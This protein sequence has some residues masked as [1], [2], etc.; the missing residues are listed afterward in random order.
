M[1]NKST[2]Y[3]IC[4][5]HNEIERLRRLLKCFGNQTFKNYKLVIVDDGS[6]DGTENFV[7]ENYQDAI[8]I[9]GDGKLWWTGSLYVAVEKILQ[10]AK[11]GDF[12]LT[13]NNDCVVTRDYL[14]NIYRCAQKYKDSIT[15]SLVVDIKDK[16]T[17]SD[18]GVRIHWEN[19]RFENIGPKKISQ[20]KNFETV[21]KKI[22]TLSTKGTLYP[23]K[24]FKSIGNF[25]R[26]HLP[27]YI[28]DYEFACRARKH[29]FKL[30][31]YYNAKVY[32]EVDRTGIG[33]NISDK[34]TIRE[35]L[36]LLF[37]RRSRINMVDHFWFVIL[38][39][40]R[41]YW[42]Q[43]LKILLHKFTGMLSRFYA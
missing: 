33:M 16:E 35:I 22:D 15:G 39:C 5:V 17:I 38:C 24:V 36:Q 28:S 18:A 7:R 34:L 2:I 11:D 25:D 4:G 10:L 12:I 14:E 42:W 37:S 40:P 1:N 43:N 9:K 23:V 32:N 6:T 20:I 19:Y 41:K 3:I 21:E 31:L 30:L 27:H 8:F 29:G 26:K 13:I